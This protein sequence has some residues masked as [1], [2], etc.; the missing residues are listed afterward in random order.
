MWRCWKRGVIGEWGARVQ[1]AAALERAVW[2]QKW[3][4][5]PCLQIDG[6]C[7]GG[8]ALGGRRNGYNV[9]RL[10]RCIFSPLPP[11]NISLS[12]PF[13]F[14]PLPLYPCFH[15]FLA[16]H[17]FFLC[18]LDPNPSILPASPL[19]ALRQPLALCPASVSHPLPLL[20]VFFLSLCLP[21][22][23]FFSTLLLLFPFLLFSIGCALTCSLTVWSLC[24]S[25]SEWAR[26]WVAQWGWGCSFAARLPLPGQS[27]GVEW[28]GEACPEV[29]TCF[30][31]KKV[32]GIPWGQQ[33]WSLEGLR[34]PPVPRPIRRGG[35]SGNE[36]L[37]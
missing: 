8:V 1:E 22:S 18:R 19:P 20:L 23:G 33:K 26:R 14:P 2:I 30:I 16:S 36:F 6:L 4:W 5:G 37:G 28:S 29:Y 10:S 12:I 11:W 31:F 9:P 35:V 27:W 32:S 24:S 15:F 13:L 3:G 25:V 7:R 17:S 34:R 21:L